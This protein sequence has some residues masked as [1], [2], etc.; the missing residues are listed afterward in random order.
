MPDDSTHTG[1]GFTIWHVGGLG[2]Y[3]GGVSQVI[4]GY[5]EYPSARFKSRALISRTTQR[6]ILSKLVKL[7]M[8]AFTVARMPSSD[9]L[10][11]HLSQQGSFLREGLLLILAR[12]RR[13]PTVA[14]LH[15]SSFGQFAIRHP[16]VVRFVLKRAR[17]VIVISQEAHDIVVRLRVP[18][19]IVLIPNAVPVGRA[20]SWQRTAVFGGAI[21]NRKGVDVLLRAWEATRD[22]AGWNLALCG[23]L[24]MD[25][26]SFHLEG[27]NV[28]GV[29]PNDE[30]IDILQQSSIAVLPSRAETMPMF[31]L[32]AMAHYNAVV[33]TP[34]GAVADV[35]SGGAGHIVPLEDPVALSAALRRLMLDDKYRS[36]LARTAY[37][38]A[39]NCYSLEAVMPRLEEAWE[40]ARR[41][42]RD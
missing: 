25:L 35:L 31:V 3:P 22:I 16:N 7:A 29:V 17:T 30:L 39:K 5:V 9:V 4:R 6:G 23:P 37:Q 36:R 1:T 8:A 38:R 13:L 28:L 10:V 14:H 24:E 41:R 11:A 26:R 2:D 12:S 15:G 18:G 32:E 33:S 42:R 34:V 27:V 40:D 19:P 21:S 20:K